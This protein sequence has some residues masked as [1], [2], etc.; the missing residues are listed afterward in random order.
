MAALG[1]RAAILEQRLDFAFETSVLVVRGL[2]GAVAFYDCPANTH[3]GGILRRSVVPS[4]AAAGG[5]GRKRSDIARR[6]AEALDYVGVL[7]VE[8]FYM[9]ERA[10]AP[11][12]SSTRSRRGCTTP[13]T[14]R[15]D[16]CGCSQF[17]NHI[18]AV[19]GWPLGATARHS[20]AE[21]VN[22]IGD[23]VDDWPR[24]AAEPGRVRPPLRQARGARGPQ[25]GPCHAAEEVKLTNWRSPWC[26]TFRV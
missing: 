13:A 6:I 15:I 24:L 10:A 9:G 4:R 11:R 12:W 2:D 20:D 7:A 21:M 14:G 19:A 16:A 23:E 3:A 1:H 25:D 5:R 22:L 17:E 8:L 18:R 26:Q